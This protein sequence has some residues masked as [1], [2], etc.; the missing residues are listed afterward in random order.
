V[1]TP[2][3]E[4][5]FREILDASVR[6]VYEARGRIRAAFPEIRTEPDQGAKGVA[7]TVKVDEGPSYSFGQVR[8]DGPGVPSAELAKIAA[9]KPGD[10]FDETKVQEAMA[11]VVKRV[12]RDGYMK[13]AC[14]EERRI[15]D[16]ART[17]GLILRVD[18]GPQYVLGTLDIQGLD[19]LTEP[20]I[21]KMW[22]IKPGQPFDA[23]Y[24][25]AFLNQVREDAVLENLGGTRSQVKPDDANHTV[26][27][28]LVFKGEPPKPKKQPG[29][30]PGNSGGY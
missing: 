7:V 26:D 30:G 15:D 12:R 11:R 22:T 16:K 14:A 18:R 24:P 2:F 25:D 21:R 5:R 27:V 3:R 17:V 8:V 10:V 1:G 6:P 9:L 4:S 28:T 23:D 13:A 20:A 19:I 29:Q